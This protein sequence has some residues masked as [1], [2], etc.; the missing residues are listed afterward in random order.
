VADS[1]FEG[2]EFIVLEFGPRGARVSVLTTPRNGMPVTGYSDLNRAETVDD[3]RA[4][5]DRARKQGLPPCPCPVSVRRMELIATLLRCACGP[6]PRAM[7]PYRLSKCLAEDLCAGFTARTGIPTMALRPAWVWDPGM[8]QRIEA[9]WQ[10]GPASEW[11]PTWEY[12][13]FVDIRDVADAVQRAL[14]RPVSGHHRML[15]C[16]A[17]IAATSPGPRHDREIRPVR[18]RPRPGPLPARTPPRPARL[19]RCG[20]HTRLAAPLPLVDLPP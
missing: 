17:D 9:Q 8:Y 14:K 11:T 18:A 15:L 20:A 10:A 16:S 3:A 6:S 13:Q 7:R 5:A 1:P 4:A 19:R 12:G 2:T